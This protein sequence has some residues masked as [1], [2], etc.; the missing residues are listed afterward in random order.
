MVVHNFNLV[1]TICLPDETNAPLVVHANAVLP[2]S[3]TLQGFK[4]VAWRNTQTAQ[5]T[6]RMQLQQFATGDTFDV[7]E[8]RHN[9]ALEQGLGVGASK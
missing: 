2:R 7:L 5:F 6:G 1:C 4:L 9:A 3:I 8:P